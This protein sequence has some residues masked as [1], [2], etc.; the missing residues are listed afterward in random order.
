MASSALRGP[1]PS[2][3]D[4]DEYL[5]FLNHVHDVCQ[6]IAQGISAP[7]LQTM[8]MPRYDA[9]KQ[10]HKWMKDCLE[11]WNVGAHDKSFRLPKQTLLAVKRSKALSQDGST[12]LSQD[13]STPLCPAICLDALGLLRNPVAPFS[14]FFTEDCR[15]DFEIYIHVLEMNIALYDSGVATP[16]YLASDQYRQ[17][18]PEGRLGWFYTITR[19]CWDLLRDIQKRQH[20]LAMVQQRRAKRKAD[21][22]MEYYAQKRLHTE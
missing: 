6:V 2:V 3:N 20:C 21:A 17:P 11:G 13:G 8:I 12:P 16:E 9:L 7:Y 15:K 10:L 1:F 4:D 18:T 22:D 5:A 19:Y 14:V